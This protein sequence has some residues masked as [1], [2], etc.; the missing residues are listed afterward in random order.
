M[1]VRL[2]VPG[3]AQGR[4]NAGGAGRL[5]SELAQR[6]SGQLFESGAW[7]ALAGGT[8]QSA[9][10]AMPAPR[11]PPYRQVDLF[12]RALSPSLDH[13]PSH[14]QQQNRRTQHACS[15]REEGQ[16]P[17]RLLRWSRHLVHPPL[18]HRAGLRGRCLH[19]RCRSGGGE[20]AA[21]EQGADNVRT[22]RP[23][24][25]RPRTAAPST[26]SSST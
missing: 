5:L 10:S 22:S 1:A 11:L 15:E 8:G 6:P 20:P 3:T 2:G 23:L 16:G 7:K 18:A 14:Q 19:G 9:R 25:R 12:P 17:P 4:P 13:H 24:A 21:V 26:S